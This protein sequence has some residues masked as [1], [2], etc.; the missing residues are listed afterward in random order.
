MF[1]GIVRAQGTLA[2]QERYGDDLRIGVD[3][4]P[5]VIGSTN[6]G[7]SVAVNGVCL[8]VSASEGRRL[9]FD[10]SA[11]SL[12]RTRLG[13]LETGSRL[14]LEPP[15]SASDPL[16]GHF[17]SGHVDGIGEVLS[18]EPDGRSHRIEVE[19]P[20]ELA[21][22]IVEKGS[23]T[24]DGVSLTVNEIDGARFGFNVVPHTWSAT[25]MQD[26][27]VGTLVNLEVDII[28]RYLAR[29]LSD[30]EAAP[31]ES[32]ITTDFLSKQG[33]APPLSDDEEEEYEDWHEAQD[34]ERSGPEYGA[35]DGI[36][37]GGPEQDRE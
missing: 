20:K 27:A 8:T 35:G 37:G 3:V 4:P 23:I 29:L 36:S 16:G 18:I 25:N 14:N 11:E 15:L 32:D 28:A 31:E 13:E 21:R 26:Y 17:V 34:E 9:S 10:V 30:R 5:E 1:T 6:P 12:S 24:V 19:A 22:Y 33:F 7:D 2:V